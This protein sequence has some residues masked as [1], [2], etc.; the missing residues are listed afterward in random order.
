MLAGAPA[1]ASRYLVRV[2][3]F[4]VPGAQVDRALDDRIGPEG[5]VLGVAPGGRTVAS[6]PSASG[7]PP[8]PD[9]VPNL[10]RSIR[11]SRLSPSHRGVYRPNP[12]DFTLSSTEGIHY[13]AAAMAVPQGILV[14]AMPLVSTEATL[15][16]LLRTEL[17][18]SVAVV[19][20]PSVGPDAP[21]P[22]AMA[23][24]TAG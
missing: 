22:G 11:L 5:Y 9:P 23:A 13:R 19:V 3:Y 14:S 7:S 18:V 8:R 6:R 2:E 21:V 4:G 20:A 1:N 17:L 24:V 12:D 15:G 16:S 10:P